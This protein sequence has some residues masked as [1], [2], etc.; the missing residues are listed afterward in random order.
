M[1]FQTGKRESLLVNSRFPVWKLF[2]YLKEI[3]KNRGNILCFE[4]LF[5]SLHAQNCIYII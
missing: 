1:S 2:L 5:V 4:L 3:L